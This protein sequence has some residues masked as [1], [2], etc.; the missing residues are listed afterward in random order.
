MGAVW[1][2][3]GKAILTSAV[4]FLYY[5]LFLK[6][7]TFHHYNRFYLLGALLVSLLLP[8]LK[9]S[10]F[11]IEVNNDM[12]EWINQWQQTI[13]GTSYE[14]KPSLNLLAL[15][16]GLVT[17]F[18]MSRFFFGI[19][20]I[21]KFKTLFPKEAFDGIH[22]YQTNLENA[23]FSYFRHL[24][25]KQSIP[26][27]SEVGKQ[28]L[29]HEMVHIEQ[30]HTYDKL[31]MELILCVCWFN[32]FYYLIKKEMHLIHEYLADKKAVNQSDTKAFAQMLLAS[33]FSGNSLA[34]SSPLLNPHLKKR[35]Q[36]LKTPR[37][38][39]SYIRRTFALPLLFA[40]SF[41]YLVQAQSKETKAVKV[42]I[43]GLAEQIRAQSEVLQTL[44]P[45][46]EAF[47]A[48]VEEINTL[49]DEIR[50]LADADK[51]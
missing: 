16:S 46:T 28:V 23:P 36:M 9:V 7:K 43:P 10:Y 3:F 32:P 47:A 49:G 51:Y 33:H 14:A 6:D 37:T 21:S 17:L 38:K 5:R 41:A 13:P 40:L 35:L 39:F 31:F 48:K 22:C 12:Y 20:K 27:N 11:T 26:L 45:G 25:W 29:K 34:V 50:K 8:L 19:F 30:K 18:L 42:E 44:D 4:L 24:F 15:G 1:L 2:Y